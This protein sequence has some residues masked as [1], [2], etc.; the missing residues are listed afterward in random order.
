MSIVLRTSPEDKYETSIEL[1][2]G[3]YSSV[4]TAKLKNSPGESTVVI[5]RNTVSNY[6]LNEI[7]TYK[8]LNNSEQFLK[9]YDV[10]GKYT[11][12]FERCM[13]NLEDLFMPQLVY[14][15][16]QKNLA[17]QFLS[18]LNAIHQKK[19]VHRDIKMRNI[20]M[21]YD[22][23]LK[24]CDFES[25]CDNDSFP[26]SNI[27]TRG[28]KP[29]EILIST[30]TLPVTYSLDLWAA[31]VILF[32][33]F[34]Q[35]R[36]FLTPSPPCDETDIQ[37]MTRMFGCPT[38]PYYESLPGY[39]EYYK[40]ASSYK[41]NNI[42]ENLVDWM[43]AHTMCEVDLVE[44]LLQ[45]E[46]SARCTAFEL[47]N[48]QSFFVQPLPSVNLKEAI[49]RYMQATKITRPPPH[50]AELFDF[51]TLN[52][53][54]S[55]SSSGTGTSGTSGTGTSG[56]SGT[57]TSGNSSGSGTSKSSSQQESGQKGVKK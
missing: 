14:P 53:N 30:S 37:M 11:L 49:K 34:T 3:K 51:K 46:P 13:C 57:G 38:G 54:Y 41:K 18:G 42:R 52:P 33:I 20:L 56:T 9:V 8:Q 50:K 1:Y 6:S 48:A 32:K 55:K 28:Y 2:K 31:G 16:E 10:C 25:V 36:K 29:F 35:N 19:L 43:S 12:V 26:T 45:L 7:K 17:L 27:G 47:M 4:C 22:G 15:E 5:K 24:I 40:W 44:K 21:T 23:I 39:P